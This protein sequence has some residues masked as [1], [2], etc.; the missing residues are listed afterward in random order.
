MNLVDKIVALVDTVKFAAEDAVYSVKNKVLDVVDFVKYDVLKQ[1][2]TFADD[3]I[4]KKPKAK[5]K[6][7]KK[8]KK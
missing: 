8:K 7:T 5:K 6:K 2:P 4:E 1:Y 3:F